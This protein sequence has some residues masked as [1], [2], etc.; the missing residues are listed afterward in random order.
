M[1]VVLRRQ[2]ATDL[3]RAATWYHLQRSGLGEAFLQA[4]QSRMTQLAKRPL[5]GSPIEGP[6]RRVL[7]D[8]FPYCIFY[9]VEV[10]QVVVL[11]VLHAARDPALWP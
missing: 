7:I 6:V 1:K 3:N 2:A 11:A 10:D 8:R 4:A 5:A 9:L